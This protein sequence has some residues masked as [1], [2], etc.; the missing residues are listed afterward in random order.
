MS[1]LPDTIKLK[2]Y[3]EEVKFILTNKREIKYLPKNGTCLIEDLDENWLMTEKLKDNEVFYLSEWGWGV[4]VDI[5]KMETIGYSGTE[6]ENQ[7]IDVY[8]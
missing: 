8:E 1:N 6:W 3:G 4:F 5:D 2:G 7:K